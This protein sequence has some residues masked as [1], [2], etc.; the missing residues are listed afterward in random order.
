MRVIF[1]CLS[2]IALLPLWSG[3][4][5]LQDAL[6]I[7]L[8]ENPKQRAAD[9]GIEAATE[10]IGIAYARYYPEIYLFASYTRREQRLFFPKLG[11]PPTIAPIFKLPKTLG[12]FN[13][14]NI[15]VASYYML[16]DSGRSRAKLEIAQAQKNVAS[17]EA[18]RVRQEIILDVTTAYY[19]VLSNLALVAVNQEQFARTQ[20]HLTLA[21]QR[22]DA[23]TAT[24]AD[25]YRVEVEVSNA[26][27]T[28]LSSQTAVRVSQGQLN[29]AMGLP[30]QTSIEIAKAI[31]CLAK[32]HSEWLENG[33]KN[34][35]EQRPEIQAALNNIQMYESH[36]KEAASRGGPKVVAEGTYGWH[37]TVFVPQVPEWLVGVSAEWPIFQ[38]YGPTFSVRQAY[39]Q[40]Y[41][42]QADLKRIE[43]Q[44]QQEVWSSYAQ[45]Q[46]AYEQL[47][48]TQTRIKNARESLR[49]I[50]Q[51][52]AVGS[53]ILTDLLDTQTALQQAETDYVTAEWNYFIALANFQWSQGYCF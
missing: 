46:Q 23:G 53:S 31:A 8:D 21:K 24:L 6:K 50:E 38:G 19:T 49:I 32:P 1:V 12:P 26:Q 13:D 17:D 48:L 18:E 27:Q 37:D 15:G 36:I 10:G 39:A 29:V 11:L 45:L 41:Q 16:Y 28:L 5:S 42:S 30:P 51:R 47:A 22:K 34:A 2:F 52:Y 7:A 3:P 4:L 40:L 9:F 25:V 43:L 35:L 33:F 20:G 14:W 44:V